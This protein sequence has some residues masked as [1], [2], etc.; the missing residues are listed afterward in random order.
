M[1][2]W[3]RYLAEFFGAFIL[4]FGG[5]TAVV[6]AGRI[7]DIQHQGGGTVFNAELIAPFAFGLALLA[8]LYAFGE[9][10]G[11][12]F[13][14]AVSLGMW[15]DRRITLGDLIGYW[16][17][18]FAGAIVASAIMLLPFTKSDVASTATLPSAGDGASFVLEAVMTG[19]FVLV[20]LQVSKSG[21]YGRTAL[22]AIPLTLIFIHFALV[23]L[24]G[25]SV[26]PARTLGPALIG[27]KWDA[28]WVYFVGPGLGAIV[29]YIVHAVVVQGDTK[30]GEQTPPPS[31]PAAESGGA[32]TA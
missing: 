22:V 1:K 32:A 12:H 2:Q 16:V 26:N 9:V 20:I 19:I 31:G 10:S 13:N 24:T 14:P 4:V 25:C 17:A 3:Q 15:L 29:A 5:C 11:G 28:E 30:L 8:G 27:N 18:Q 6:A 23:T 7:T 21:T